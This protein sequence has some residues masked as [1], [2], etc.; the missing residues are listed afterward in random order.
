M[1]KNQGKKYIYYRLIEATNNRSCSGKIQGKFKLYLGKKNS[2][3]YNSWFSAIS[4]RNKIK[5]LIRQ[6]QILEIQLKKLEASPQV[7]SGRLTPDENPELDNKDFA[8]LLKIIDSLET[9]INQ[10]NHQFQS[11]QSSVLGMRC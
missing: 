3:L 2:S 10:I 9:Q 1:P 5:S 6:K 4:R 11:L 8:H 7:S